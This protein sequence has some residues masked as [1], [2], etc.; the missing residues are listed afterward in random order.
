MYCQKCY[1]RVAMDQ[2]EEHNLSCWG[3]LTTS[4]NERPICR[5]Q[6]YRPNNFEPTSISGPLSGSG[7]HGLTMLFERYNSPL[8]D[9][10]ETLEFRQFPL[11]YVLMIPRVDDIMN[12]LMETTTDMT[13]LHTLRMM[14]IIRDRVRVAVQNNDFCP[15]CLESISQQNE[16]Y[17]YCRD[18]GQLCGQGVHF[19]CTGKLT[20]L[21]LSK[22]SK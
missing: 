12:S 6:T 17:I 18:D 5:Y 21:K 7:I 1:K 9:Y 20:H 4:S 14:T 15:L 10:N 3:Q 16:I 8:L 22:S 11:F 2:L 19:V 13:V